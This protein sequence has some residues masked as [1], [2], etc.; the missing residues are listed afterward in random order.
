MKAHTRLGIYVLIGRKT[1]AYGRLMAAFGDSKNSLCVFPGTGNQFLLVDPHVFGKLPRNVLHIL[2][3]VGAR[4]SR[5]VSR[6]E[7]GRVGFD[8]HAVGWKNRH[9]FAQIIRSAVVADPAGNADAE[10]HFQI[11][12]HGRPVA[13]EAVHHRTLTDLRMSFKYR[14]KA[15]SSI[16]FMQEHRHVQLFGDLDVMLQTPYLVLACGIHSVEVKTAFTDRKQSLIGGKQLLNADKI[17]LPRRVGIVGMNSGGA[18]RVMR[19]HKAVCQFI[20]LHIRAGDD[21]GNAFA[22]RVGQYF[23]GMAELSAK[24]VQPDVVVLNVFYDN[25]L[26]DDS[27]AVQNEITENKLHRQ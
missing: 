26:P 19:L 20:R 4:K 17:L 14:R 15:L 2:R 9:G 13:R 11:G 8:E 21:A 27:I 18:V 12:C 1:L 22:Q 6:C 5:H 7:V 16:S 10:T 25:S 23:F 3:K 24:Q